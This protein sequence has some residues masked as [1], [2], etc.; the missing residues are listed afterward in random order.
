MDVPNYPHL[1]GLQ[2]ANALNSSDQQ[3]GLLIGADQYY[4][5]VL[6]EV[7]KGCS[8]PI[9]VSGKLCHGPERLAEIGRMYI[10]KQLN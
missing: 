7:I 4:E 6:G 5:V 8:G 1:T 2:F 10:R 9:D 3:I